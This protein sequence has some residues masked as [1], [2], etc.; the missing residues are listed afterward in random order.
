MEAAVGD[1]EGG[2]GGGGRGKRGR[3][4]GGGEMVE[5]VWG[6]TGSTASRIY[7]VRATGGKDRHSKVYTAKGIR[8]RRVR[9]SVATAIQFYDL[10][11]R[12]GFDQPSKAIEWLINAA[13]P[14]IDTLP[15]LDP[16]AFAAIPHAAADAA[17]TRRRSQQQ[18]QQL[19]NKSGCSSTSET[20][21][22]SDK[23]VT[24]A[25]APAQAA[26]FT[27]LLIA[28][29]AASSAG[30]GAIG[31]GADCVGI[32]HPGKGG[33]EGASTYGFSAAS[34]FG[35]APPIGMVPA[36]PFNF[37]APGADMAAHYSLAQ[38]QLAAPPP[39]AGGDYNLNFSMSSGFLGANRGTLQSNSPSNMSGHHHHHHQQQLQ[40]LDG[41]TISFLLGHAAAAAHP[42]AS[43]G[44]ITST[45]ALQLWD[46]F[47]HSGMKEKS[48]N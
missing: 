33:A 45:A 7:R 41:S 4:G 39:P 11:D 8:D 23:E 10:Q 25:S 37:S 32:A 29:V 2:G 26:S 9:L 27:E 31:N 43:E 28:G 1:G 20:S 6:Q 47:R 42:A 19:S 36:P 18:Q 48:K 17:P 34:S 38:D 15:S 21:K 30:G 35:D 14:A 24:V 46:G 40:R 16:A 3:G 5:A 13:S 12:L 22:G 44:Q